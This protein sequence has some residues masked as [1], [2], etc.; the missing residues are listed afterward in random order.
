MDI[1]LKQ[2]FHNPE[3]MSDAE[4][5]IMRVKLQNQRRL[6]KIAAGMGFVGAVAFDV[7]L[8][9]RNPVMA[10]AM[11]GGLASYA[12]AG[13]GTGMETKNVLKREFDTDILIAHE[14]RQMSRFM[15]LSG[16]GQNWI[17]RSHNPDGNTWE[18][19]Y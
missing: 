6:P 2:L 11:L 9:R 17:H 10:R 14:Y 5:D 8:L 13:Y 18:K 1:E 7:V 4:L 3:E 19:P 12:L 15:N 16:Y